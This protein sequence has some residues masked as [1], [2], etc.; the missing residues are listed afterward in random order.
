VAAPR[1]LVEVTLRDKCPFHTT[2]HDAM[3]ASESYLKSCLSNIL[4]TDYRYAIERWIVDVSDPELLWHV[5]VDDDPLDINNP[6]VDIKFNHYVGRDRFETKTIEILTSSGFVL[7]KGELKNGHI[8]G[9]VQPELVN[10]PG[11]KTRLTIA[12]E[13]NGVGVGPMK[14]VSMTTNI[15][16]SFEFLLFSVRTLNKTENSFIH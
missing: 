13:I 7:H 3:E 15:L 9:P 14:N 6:M 4:K 1:S 12:L 2:A 16:K 10:H 11:W 8:Y 5:T